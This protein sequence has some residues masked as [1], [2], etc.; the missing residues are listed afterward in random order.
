MIAIVVL[1]GARLERRRS[2]TISVSSQV[3]R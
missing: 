1:C 2:H 3:R